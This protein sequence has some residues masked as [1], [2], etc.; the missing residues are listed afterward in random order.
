MKPLGV[1]PTSGGQFNF[2][3]AGWF[4]LGGHRGGLTGELP[5]VGC[6]SFCRRNVPDR[7]QQFVVVHGRTL[8]DAFSEVSVDA[9]DLAELRVITNNELDHVEQY[10]CTRYN[11]ARSMTQRWIDDGRPR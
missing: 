9:A 7:L 2:V 5:I 1:C 6:L 4:K 10:H 11:L 8:E 3:E